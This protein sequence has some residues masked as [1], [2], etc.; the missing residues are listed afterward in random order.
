MW[1]QQAR[2]VLLAGHRGT[3]ATGCEN[4]LTAFRQGI[5]AGID[6]LETDIRQTRDGQLILMHDERADRTTDGSGLIC[7]MTLRQVKKLN[8]ARDAGFFE[9]PPTL[10]EALE[11]LAPR[12]DLMFNFEL[13]DYPVPGREEW[14]LRSC[15]RALDAIARFGLEDRCVIN[16]FS[17]RLLEHVDSTA[18]GRWRL[19][20]FYPWFILNGASRDPRTYLFCACLFPEEETPNGRR[21]LASHV[22]PKEWFDELKAQGIEPWVGANV[23]TEEDVRKSL[24][25]GARAI[26]CDDPASMAEILRRLGAR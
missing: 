3:R 1:N 5:A 2:D 14:A 16:S 24:S 6:M 23:K 9:A 22:C 26:C 15:D 20:G 21:P 13:K 11:M 17:A 8:A 4:T 12:P 7:E 10:E 25:Y 18:P 19:H